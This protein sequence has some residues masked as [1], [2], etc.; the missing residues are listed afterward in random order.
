MYKLIRKTKIINLKEGRNIKS[1]KI[2]IDFFLMK[3]KDKKP[4]IIK[5]NC[6]PNAPH[7]TFLPTS[8]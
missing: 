3:Y 7:A 8:G 4:E 2:I 5:N 6:T 1:R